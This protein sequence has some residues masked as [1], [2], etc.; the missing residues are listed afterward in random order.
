[1]AR[2]CNNCGESKDVEDAKFCEK[3]HFI[4]KDCVWKGVGF[5]GST[6]K[7]CP[8]CKTELK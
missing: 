3:D 8:I 4:C 5:F 7:Y 2:K 6:L 1:M